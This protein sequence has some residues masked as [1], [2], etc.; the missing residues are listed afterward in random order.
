MFNK[1]WQNLLEDDLDILS[2][3]VNPHNTQ[4]YSQAGRKS[5]RA[6]RTSNIKQHS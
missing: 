4:L 3:I 1:N 6:P 5:E 2:E